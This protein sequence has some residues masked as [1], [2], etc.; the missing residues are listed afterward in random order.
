[1]YSAIADALAASQHTLQWLGVLV[2]APMV[3]LIYFLAS[4]K[5]QP[6]NGRLLASAPGVLIALFYLGAGLVHVRKLSTPSFGLPFAV[7][8]LL[9]LGLMLLSFAIFRGPKRVHL[10]Q[11]VNLV[12][13]F[14]TFF[15]GSMA[16]TG[17]WL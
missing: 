4:P 16:V 17:N 2:A 9:P 6:M 11:L 1:M 7:M 5:S 8:L 15:V 13:L 12:C 3:S 10:L 14:W